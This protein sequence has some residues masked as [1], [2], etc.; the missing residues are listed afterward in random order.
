MNFFYFKGLL[1]NE[2]KYKTN[3][4]NATQ[5]IYLFS[6]VFKECN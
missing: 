3:H 1:L 2:I 6:K 4:K 5:N